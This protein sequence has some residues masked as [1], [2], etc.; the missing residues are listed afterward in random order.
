MSKSEA[1]GVDIAKRKFD[2]AIKREQK[3]RDKSFSNDEAGF[4][5]LLKWLRG[6]SAGPLHVCMEATGSY[7]EA[8]ALFLHE[9]GVSVSVVNAAR[10]A[11]YAKSE[12]TRNK[13]DKQDARTIASYC[14]SKSPELWQPPSPEIRTLR[15]LVRRV[16]AL[17][18]LQQQERNR[19]D[20]AGAAVRPSIEAM[21]QSVEQQIKTLLHTIKA[22]IKAHPGLKDQ[23]TLLDSIPAVGPATIR[24]VLAEI[25]DNVLKSVRAAD[26]FTGLAPRQHESAT[27]KKRS[28]MSKQ[29]S[30]RL[31]KAL[32]MPAV[33]A[34]THNPVIKAFYERML[35]NG[36][37]K[38]QAV[39]AAMRK[40][41]HLIVG[42]LKSGKAFDP[43]LHNL[44]HA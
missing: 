42:V 40:L 17:M 22:H 26:A 29:G 41:L 20:V 8:L 5:A 27:L 35:R 43:S 1:A 28:K 32:Y 3:W 6:F 33:V 12:G 38:K 4:K 37:T 11:H 44:K 24:V 15:E 34:I 36:L 19:L 13:T 9:A 2:A 23:A 39:C 31:R 18:E 14:E 25:P 30:A 7:G 21:L 10:I 16:D